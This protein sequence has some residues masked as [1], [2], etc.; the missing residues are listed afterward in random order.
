GSAIGSAPSGRGAFPLP[1]G[2]TALPSLGAVIARNTIRDSLGG[3]MIG[4]EH[5]VNYWESRVTSASESGRV[6][7]TASVT[8]NT[9]VFDSGFLAAWASAYAALGNNPAEDSTPPT[10]TIGSGW[11]AEPP[12]PYGSP[13]F[14][15]TVGGALSANGNHQPIF[16]DPIEN[17]ITVQGNSLR[18]IAASGTTTLQTEPSGQVYAATVNG[19]VYAPRLTTEFYQNQPYN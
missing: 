17:V 19:K 1:E 11:S 8:G 14:P 5:T 15:W 12:G 6:F 13:R 3:I 4:V 2:W 16:V 18:I 10:L 9:F 7:V